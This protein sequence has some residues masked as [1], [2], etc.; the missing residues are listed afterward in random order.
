MSG[1][2]PEP[3]TREHNVQ[4]FTCGE[5][6][7]DDWLRRHALTTQA[8]EASRVFVVT[9]DDGITVRGFYAI[10]ASQVLPGEVT[11][12]SMK[13]QPPSR[14]QPALLL[15]RF[16][17]DQR[18]QGRGLR[19]SLLQDAMVRCAAAADMVGARVLLVHAK[20]EPAKQF[21]LRFG[22]EESP[23][24]PLHLLLLMKDIRRMIRKL[25]R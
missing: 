21:Y 5:P 20:D 24:D 4:S 15:A 13:G 3:L 6:E 10:A 11:A 19:R 9:G 22:F 25:E 16:G 18:H 14:P 2:R 1:R 23:S 17:V 12:R 8:S 7:L